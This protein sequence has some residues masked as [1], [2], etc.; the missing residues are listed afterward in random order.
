MSFTLIHAKRVKGSLEM[1]WMESGV[2]GS[3]VRNPILT[4]G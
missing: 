1:R 3:E 2:I 4:Y